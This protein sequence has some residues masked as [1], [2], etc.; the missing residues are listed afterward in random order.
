MTIEE[1]IVKHTI[2]EEEVEY[3]ADNE[4]Q[5]LWHVFE[6][7]LHMLVWSVINDGVI[8]EA[9]IKLIMDAMAAHGVEPNEKTRHYCK[10]YLEQEMAEFLAK[11][12]DETPEEAARRHAYAEAIKEAEEERQLQAILQDRREK[13]RQRM[14]SL[15]PEISS[16][17]EGLAGVAGLQKSERN[18][19]NFVTRL[20]EEEKTKRQSILNL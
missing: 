18:H 16:I 17:I 13:E 12:P 4:Q 10:L 2:P 8:T 14:E 19:T 20:S 11:H 3:V 15:K 1:D 9:E 7:N 6:H 5:H